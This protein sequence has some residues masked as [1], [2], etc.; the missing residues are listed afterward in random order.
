MSNLNYMFVPP[1]SL[2]LGE[3][4]LKSFIQ[5][6]VLYKAM[7]QVVLHQPG[8]QGVARWFDITLESDA[9]PQYYWLVKVTFSTICF[10]KCLYY[11]DP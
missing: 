2:K 4:M 9:Y 11:C 1:C 8:Y 10:S 6:S 7:D 5:T 3:I